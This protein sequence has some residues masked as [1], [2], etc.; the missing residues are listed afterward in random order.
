VE[1][2]A[3]TNPLLVLPVVQ[4]EAV[5]AAFRVEEDPVCP[6]KEILAVAEELILQEAEVVAAAQVVLEV[7]VMD[8]DPVEQVEQV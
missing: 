2:E 7:L 4:V 6:G 3:H 1:E 5:E 8:P